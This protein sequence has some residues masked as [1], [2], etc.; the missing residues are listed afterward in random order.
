MRRINTLAT[1]ARGA[2]S[3]VVCCAVVVGGSSVLAGAGSPG[4]SAGGTVRIDAALDST[5]MVSEAEGRSQF[6]SRG[7]ERRFSVE[8]SRLPAGPYD[9]MVGGQ[10]RGSIE[11]DASGAGELR[12]ASRLPDDDE[13]VAKDDGSDEILLTFDPRGQRVEVVQDG[14]VVLEVSFP[15]QPA[16][17]NRH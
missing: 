11:A 16:A 4:R 14:A 2:A 12:F 10:L 5:G 1:L 13:E 3:L 7:K 9:L 8:V 6:L 17:G 15:S